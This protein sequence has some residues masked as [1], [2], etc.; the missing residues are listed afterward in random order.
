VLVYGWP[1]GALYAWAASLAAASLSYAVGRL[2]PRARVRGR[3]PAQTMWLRGQLRRRG[4]LAVAVARLVPVGNFSVT[5]LVAGSLR[6]PFLRFLAGSALG[7]LPG[8]LAMA[9]FIDRVAKA[10]RVPGVANLALLAALIT[11]IGWALWWLGRRLARS[12]PVPRSMLAAEGA[13]P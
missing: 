11:A 12:T 4:L 6:V 5:N 2:L 3:W 7:V 1:R 9:L 10:V 8:I 13:R